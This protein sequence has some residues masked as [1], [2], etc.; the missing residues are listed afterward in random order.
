MRKNERIIQVIFGV[1]DE[2]NKQLP[3]EQQMDRS[4]DTVLI[5]R[6]GKLIHW[7]L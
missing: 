1:V 3:E 2:V 7:D 5:G 4:F 6:L